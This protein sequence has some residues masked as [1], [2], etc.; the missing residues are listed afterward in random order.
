MQLP[1]KAPLVENAVVTSAGELTELV[2]K[3]LGEGKGAFLKVFAKDKNAKYYATVLF[4]SS[5]VLAVECLVVD[6]KQTLIGED[7]VNLL[8]SLLGRPMVVDV[9]SLDEIEMKLSIA[10]NLDVYSETPK[11]PLDE[12]FSG[13][14]AQP[15]EIGV[16]KQQPAPEEKPEKKEPERAP[17]PAAP[18]KPSEEPAQQAPVQKTQAKPAE[19][20]EPEV[21]VNFTG[22]SIPEGAFKKYA[23]SIIKEASRIKGVSINRVEFDANVGEGVVYLNVRVY[24]SSESTDRRSLEIAEKRLFHIVSKHAPIILREAEYKPILRDISV[25]LNGEEARPQ[26]IVEK[27]K[28]KSGA[29][30]KDGRIQLSV[31]EDVWPYFSNFARTVVKELETAGIKVNKAY[32]DVKGRREL[33]INLSIA[34]ESP[35]DRP[36]TEKTIRTILTRH[37]K[38]LSS[39]LNRY[40][41]VH[42]V[43]LELVERAAARPSPTKKPVASGKAAEILAKKELLEKEVEKLLKEA[44][45]D[46]LA[47][48]T[49]EKKKEAEKTLLRSRIEPAIETLKGRI[50]AE[51]KLIPRVTFKWLKLNHEIQGSTVYVDIEASFVKETV[52]G[53]FGAYSGV[54]DERIKRDITETI[55]R[56]IRDVS[57]EYSVAIRPRN[58]NVILR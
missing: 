40:I 56:I 14:A 11:I 57:S 9:Y 50:H 58:I 38:G 48:L 49:E 30:T 54:S 16:P 52:G 29:V 46:E 20:G 6:N 15:P 27:D 13:G 12:F 53:L 32:F 36:T 51:L 31:L 7:A 8:K 5:K 23:E 55:N 33:E 26:E 22:G 3:A 41:T 45:I 25:V 17:T 42:N 1:D 24:G 4:D 19:G 47:P 10:E 44:G 28:K 18:Q 37:A 39:S 21:V 35:F 43:E 2:K 34:V